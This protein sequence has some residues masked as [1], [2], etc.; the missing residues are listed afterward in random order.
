MRVQAAFLVSFSIGLASAV[1]ARAETLED[2]VAAAYRNNPTLA[3]ARLSVR[4]AS[5]Q[6]LQ[7]RANYRPQVD[8]TADYVVRRLETESRG[9]FGLSATQQ[10]LSGRNVVF[11]GVQRIYSGGRRRAQSDQAR[12]ELGS[13][14]EG[15]RLA[16][17]EVLLRTITAYA[18]VLRDQE[19]VRIRGA[20]AEG[21]AQDLRGTQRRLDVGDVTRTDLSQSQA[22]LARA[23]AGEVIARADL[24]GSRATY[25]AIVGETP[26]E[27]APLE[28]PPLPPASLEEAVAEAEDANPRLLQSRQEI[29]SARAR[30]GIERS[31]LEPNIDVIGSVNYAEDL[32]QEGDLSQGAQ[33]TARF[34]VPLYEGGFLE[35]RVRQSR[36]DVQRAEQRTEALRRQVVANVVSTWHDLNAAVQ[37]VSAARVQLEADEA[38]LHGVRREQGVGLRSTL[39]VLNAQQELLDSQLSL[40]RAEHDA[41]LGVFQ[42]LLAMGALDLSALGM[43]G[44]LG[45][46]GE[47][48]PPGLA[49]HPTDHGAQGDHPND[50][51][52]GEVDQ[53]RPG[54]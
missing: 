11:R 22:R 43:E 54:R 39:D 25:E 17:Q 40:V 12:A 19:S 52:D 4:S 27:L 46:E 3:E 49:L 28:T 42:L 44:E 7:A 6:R 1:S 24:E 15:L 5:E 8:F 38:A 35:S 33:V 26:T 45:A 2:A 37:G 10:D 20:F 16:E 32:S 31:G 21:L 29:A 47:L 34:S 13:A 50:A 53:D 14:Q 9:L 18:G 51:R 36:I 23:Q 48:V 30:A 41:Y